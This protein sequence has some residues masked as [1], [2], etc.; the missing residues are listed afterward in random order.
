MEDPNLTVGTGPE[1]VVL[2]LAEN[3]VRAGF[4]AND[5]SAVGALG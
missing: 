3:A 2:A 4:C 5:V 1:E